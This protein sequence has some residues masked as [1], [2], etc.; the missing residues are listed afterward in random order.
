VTQVPKTPT[1]Q[2]TLRP[3]LQ[4]DPTPAHQV[5]GHV[6]RGCGCDLLVIG[7]YMPRHLYAKLKYLKLFQRPGKGRGIGFPRIP[8]I[9]KDCTIIIIIIYNKKN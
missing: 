3:T 6:V 5:N 8:A 2:L 4:V 9:L 7:Y 1:A